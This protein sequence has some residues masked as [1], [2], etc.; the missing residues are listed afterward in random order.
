MAMFLSDF[1]QF[2]HYIIYFEVICMKENLTGEASFT[3]EVIN[4]QLLF[5]NLQC[6]PCSQM[7]LCGNNLQCWYVCNCQKKRFHVLDQECS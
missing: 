5:L 1:G 7:E 2:S 3:L 4:C 6:L